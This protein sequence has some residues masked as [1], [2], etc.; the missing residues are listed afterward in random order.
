MLHSTAI[1]EHYTGSRQTFRLYF[2]SVA[3]VILAVTQPLAIQLHS[4]LD[5]DQSSYRA[6]LHTAAAKHHTLLIR[7]KHHAHI[8]NKALF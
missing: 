8:K 3:C 1:L 7:V 4:Y 2:I 5:H 6:I